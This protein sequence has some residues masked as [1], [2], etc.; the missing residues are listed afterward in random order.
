MSFA[1]LGAELPGLSVHSNYERTSEL[2][3]M[4]IELGQSFVGVQNVSSNKKC[5]LFLVCNPVEEVVKALALKFGQKAV[6]IGDKNNNMEVVATRS[7]GRTTLGKLAATTKQK[8]ASSKF[9][10]YFQEDGRDHYFYV[11]QKEGV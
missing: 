2:R 4:L 8:A 7:N 3:L 6:L 10:I 11:A 5:Q 9:H 1:L